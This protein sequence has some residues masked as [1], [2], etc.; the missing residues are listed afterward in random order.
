MKFHVICHDVDRLS[1]EDSLING[2]IY[3]PACRPP[4]PRLPSVCNCGRHNSCGRPLIGRLS[5]FA[6]FDTPYTY[7][8]AGPPKPGPPGYWS[9][10]K[11]PVC[12]CDFSITVLLLCV[13][14]LSLCYKSGVI[15]IWTKN[16]EI[17]DYVH[18][19]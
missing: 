14:L 17:I 12:P 8:C 5:P 6:M 10:I 18:V 13:D 4:V 7:S 1:R 9:L 3:Q 15:K 11:L 2:Y 16:G 19:Q